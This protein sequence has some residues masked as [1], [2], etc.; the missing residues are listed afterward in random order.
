MD[1]LIRVRLTYCYHYRGIVHSIVYLKHPF[2]KIHEIILYVETTQ[3]QTARHNLIDEWRSD[4]G[5]SSG[6]LTAS[7]QCQELSNFEVTLRS[8]VSFVYL[9]SNLCYY[10]ILNKLHHPLIEFSD[11]S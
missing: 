10:F 8:V 4:G 2:A 6:R 11:T 7:S 9:H 5:N 3:L 1:T